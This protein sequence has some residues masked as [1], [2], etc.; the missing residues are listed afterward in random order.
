LN[1]DPELTEGEYQPS[2]SSNHPKWLFTSE[3]LPPNEPM[4][5]Q[6]L[7]L[8]ASQLDKPGTPSQ[9]LDAGAA[10]TGSIDVVKMSPKMERGAEKVNSGAFYGASNFTLYN[11]TFNDALTEPLP[12]I[13]MHHIYLSLMKALMMSLVME[14]FAMHASPGATFDSSERDPPP[15]CHPGTRLETIEHTRVFFDASGQQKRV[16]WIVGPAGVGKSA[17]MQSVSET[18]TNLGGSFFF[19]TDVHDDSSRL[20]VTLAYQIAVKHVPY[21]DHLRQRLIS[22]PTLFRKAMTAQFNAFFVAPFT[23]SAI[24]M[25]TENLLLLIDGL[26]ECSGIGD[27]RQLLELICAFTLEHPSVPLLWIIASRPEP[28]ITSFFNRSAVTTIHDKVFLMVNSNSGRQDVERYLR[29]QLKEIRES[30]PVLSYIPSWPLEE[31]FLPLAMAADGLFIFATTALRFIKNSSLGDPQSQLRILLDVLQTDRTSASIPAEISTSPLAHLYA[32]YEGILT[33]VPI[34]VFPDTYRLLVGNGVIDDKIEAW[35]SFMWAC[36]FLGMSPARAYSAFHHL[37]SVL[38][39]PVFPDADHQRIRCHHKSF[40]DYLHLKFP[41]VKA[42]WEELECDSAV[43][44]FKD[45]PA[46]ECCDKCLHSLADVNRFEASLGIRPNI[47]SCTGRSRTFHQ[48]SKEQT[49]TCMH[50]TISPSPG[51]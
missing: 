18:S 33:R 19:A 9:T 45:I 43:R 11:P 26:D 6:Q 47:L 36:S 51:S 2:S 5:I 14:R 15:R 44:I 30:D 37:H 23:E 21:R 35:G 42:D 27:Q 12:D 8:D 34:H 4:S 40:A 50:P 16:L 1:V 10:P 38:D 29:E 20:F 3:A 46:C 39:V 49:S 22:D 31:E 41:N 7:M 32:L 48:T 17:I 13:C 28:H 24:F 25:T